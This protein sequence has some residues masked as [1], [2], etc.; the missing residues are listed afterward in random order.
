MHI[1][2]ESCETC[3]HESATLS[4]SGQLLFL[5]GR[6]GAPDPD[7]FLGE[8]LL[9]WDRALRSAGRKLPYIKASQATVLALSDFSGKFQWEWTPG[10]PDEWFHHLRGVKNSAHST[11]RKHQGAIDM[12]CRY[13][14]SPSYPWAEQAARLFGSTFSEVITE[15][16]RVSH[17]Q[18][19]EGRPQKR[20]FTQHELQE[21]FDLADLEYERVLESPRRNGALAVLRDTAAF[22][23]AYSFGLRVNEV[24]HLQIVDLS[25]NYRA[26]Y[27]GDYGTLH[28]RWG[29]S[30]S[31]SSFKPRHVLTVFDWS[32]EV[33]DDWMHSGLPWFG[34]PMT[35]L[36]PTGQ[37]GL[38]SEAQLWRRLNGYLDELGF[39]AGLDLH[40]FRRSYATHLQTIYGYDTKFVQMQMGHEHSSTTSIYTLPAPDFAANELN[41]IHG[42]AIAASGATIPRPGKQLK[43]P[44]AS[45]WRKNTREARRNR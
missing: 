42:E 1:L 15:L 9:G 23:V 8:V 5:P 2:Q 28:V 29:K 31:G 16:N 45:V 35:D 21:L 18:E 13:A 19:S 34:K 32:A 27:F 12:F 37:G 6:D 36:F 14:C 20:A 10:D 26:P 25:P 22:K 7:R 38:V 11:I 33:L 41:R 4:G 43:L 40:S 17:K 3:I 30:S 44:P 39:A 24:R